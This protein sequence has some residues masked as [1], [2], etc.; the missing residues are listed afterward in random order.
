MTDDRIGEIW[1]LPE[2]YCKPLAFGRAI[3]AEC[4]VPE[5]YVPVPVEPSDSQ[6][7]VAV[8]FALNV[9]ICSDYNWSAYMRDV[10]ARMLA[11]APKPEKAEP[12]RKLNSEPTIAA[13]VAQEPTAFLIEGFD[14]NGKRV[15]AVIQQNADNARNSASVFAE[16]YPSVKTSGLY[17]APPDQ[18]AEVSMTPAAS[19]FKDEVARLNAEVDRL[20]GNLHA[21]KQNALRDVERI[22]ELERQQAVLVEAL[23]ES[24]ATMRQWRDY[25]FHPHCFP[26]NFNRTQLAL[27]KVTEALA[28]VKGNAELKGGA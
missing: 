12:E 3:E 6:L 19:I 15:A 25:N 10:Y 17:L 24:Q 18:S 13:P 9:R 22:A 16:H 7:D 21:M 26:E 4:R 2:N 14:G 11:A 23:E 20:R 1:R 8:S 28:S 27:R 5:G